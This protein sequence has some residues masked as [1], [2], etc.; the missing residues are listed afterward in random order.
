[1]DQISG[2]Q[3]F[4]GVKRHV[5][6][7][8]TPDLFWTKVTD[9]PP[10]HQVILRR[11][12]IPYPDHYYVFMEQFRANP[13]DMFQLVPKVECFLVRDIQFRFQIIF[14]QRNGIGHSMQVTRRSRVR[15]MD[16]GMRSEEHTSELQSL[17][18]ISY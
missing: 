8:G 17:M 14:I 12:G 11:L 9:S 4:E 10:R 2:F 6:N 15:R 18:R 5:L 7:S 1:M 13:A 16:I 3:V